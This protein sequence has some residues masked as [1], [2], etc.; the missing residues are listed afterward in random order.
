MNGKYFK[1]IAFILSITL[2]FTSILT[3]C[4][5]EPRVADFYVKYGGTGDGLTEKTPAGSVNAVKTAINEQ[6]SEGDIANVATSP[7][8]RRRGVAAAL[9]S[10]IVDFANKKGIVHLMLE[11]RASN[12]GAIALYE[13]FGFT[14]V[15]VR[16]NY[17]SKPTEDADIMRLE[18]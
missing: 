5:T 11:V 18:L 6:L 17:Y 7:E 10:N 9:M 4:G 2:V 13:K 8:H 3:A 1:L 12:A 15:A 14:K 16:K